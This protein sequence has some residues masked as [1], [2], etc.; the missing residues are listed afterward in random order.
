MDAASTP[1][2]AVAALFGLNTLV[3]HA[4]G[5]LALLAVAVY[6]FLVAVVLPLPGEVVV[7][8]AG[9]LGFGL[10][11]PVQL[12]LVV[13]VGGLGK[14]A[15][16]VLAL[17][18]GHG[19]SRSGLAE[20]ALRRLGFDP[21]AWAESR[22]VDFLTDYG[23]VGLAAGLCVPGFPDT[24]SVYAFSVVERDYAKFALAA[25]VGSVGRLL[26]VALLLGGARG[27]A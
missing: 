21:L 16:S 15:G 9:H 14:A 3:R 17:H 25:F 4:T 10:G 20:R 18:L 7:V 11:Y 1:T 27:V 23:Y 22:V 5:P 2:L 6:S 19:A 13:L 8:A 24:L 12:A 26:V